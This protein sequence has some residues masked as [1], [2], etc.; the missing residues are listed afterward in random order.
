MI[1]GTY[2]SCEKQLLMV[3]YNGTTMIFYNGTTMILYNTLQWYKIYLNWY[4]NDTLQ[5]Y[6]TMVVYNGTTMIFYNAM[7]HIYL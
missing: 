5:W 1:K 6:T 4:N 2:I 3:F 7:S